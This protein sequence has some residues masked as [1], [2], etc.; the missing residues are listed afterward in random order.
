MVDPTKSPD[1]PELRPR[2]P[3]KLLGVG[4][5]AFL[6][7]VSCSSSPEIAPLDYTCGSYP[8]LSPSP[9]DGTAC[10][11]GDANLVG[12]EPQFP[13]DICATLPATRFASDLSPPSED[14]QDTVAIQDALTQC[15]GRA[16]K[17]VANG[18][19]NAFIA[20]HL[21]VDSTT[22]WIDAGV[23]LY[24]SRN[25]DLYQKTGSCGVLGVN[26]SSACTDF[27]TM[28]G[29]GPAIMGDGVIDGQGGE[30]LVGHDY[31][32]W[33]MSYA[34]R[35]TDGS[36]G[37]PTLINTVSKTTG[38]V[39]YRITLHNSPKF[40]VKLT[41]TLPAGVNCDRRGQGFTV[42]GVTVLTPSKW[43]N[44][45][46]LV[47]TPGFARNTDGI[48]PGTTSIATCGL[49]ACNTIS[50]GD[51]HIAI[52]GGHWVSD[53]TIAHNHFGSGH[54]MSVGSETYG[55]Y[56]DPVTMV[57]HFGVENVDIYDLTVDADSRPVGAEAQA[58]DFNGIRIK[59][60]ESRGG[61]VK[62]ISYRD[63]CMRDMTNSIL[64]STA[65]NP[66]FAG[67]YF[68]QFSELSFH[69]IHHVSCLG[70]RQPVMTLNGF[71]S[72]LPA[73]PITL[74]NVFVDNFGAQTVS[75]QF[76]NVILGPGQSTVADSL[77]ALSAH[78]VPGG[79]GHGLTVTDSRDP[80]QFHEP[81]RCVFPTLPA[82]HPPP[83]WTY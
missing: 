78:P 66:L 69:D 47:L 53:L 74:D 82:P 42:W 23:T 33:Q 27:I 25:A 41:S 49:M 52:K 34:L 83:G 68:P 16:V 26:D 62:N 44:S 2:T 13:T 38:L 57:Q 43:T 46:G 59:S 58:A 1:S 55:S 72:V 32:W 15:H 10:G 61:N 40:H 73:G 31:S 11:A 70:L 39:L 4:S 56:L 17:L 37:N 81:K 60:D 51:D 48:D 28:Q 54:G 29:A 35:E 63:V 18:T 76:S 5:A 75:G 9:G 12:M 19:N 79:G 3:S 77:L 24:A 7:L 65:Y 67:T 71:N 21:T 14:N 64:I 20:S 80:A 22:L 50:T 36:I 6:A 45:Q 8:E 30:P